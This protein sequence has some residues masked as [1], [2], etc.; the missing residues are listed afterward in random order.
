MNVQVTALQISTSD[1]IRQPSFIDRAADLARELLSKVPNSSATG[2]ALGSSL[3]WNTLRTGLS[4]RRGSNTPKNPK[5]NGRLAFVRTFVGKVSQKIKN[6]VNQITSKL[7]PKISPQSGQTVAPIYQ[8]AKLRANIAKQ[9]F[10][11]L[12]NTIA[13]GVRSAT[14]RLKGWLTR[15][16]SSCVKL[17]RRGLWALHILAAYQD[18]VEKYKERLRKGD[19]EAEAKVSGGAHALLKG[20]ATLAAGYMGAKIGFA[21]GTAIPGLGNVVGAVVGFGLGL[22]VGYVFSAGAS[23]VVD[24]YLTH[25]VENAAKACY[26][27]APAVYESAKASFKKV[28]E[29]AKPAWDYVKNAAAYLF[30]RRAQEQPSV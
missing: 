11:P 26:R 22:A 14:E 23:Y 21:L 9:K 13:N 28:V 16:G 6:T 20:S 2:A 25:P 17:G 8:N 19:S 4:R 7:K 3:G 5:P 18:G 12:A 29:V 30:G 24:K 27:A 15:V 10:K 1:K